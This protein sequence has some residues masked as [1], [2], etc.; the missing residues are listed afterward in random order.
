MNQ[1]LALDLS[2]LKGVSQSAVDKNKKG[3]F[4]ANA[5]QTQKLNIS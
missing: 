1:K 2:K 4:A 5:Q 3:T